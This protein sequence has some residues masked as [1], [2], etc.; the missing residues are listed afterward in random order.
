MRSRPFLAPLP[1]GADVQ[2]RASAG[3]RQEGLQWR[4][5]DESSGGSLPKDVMEWTTSHVK[6]WLY[7]TMPADLT[8]YE[9]RIVVRDS[10]QIKSKLTNFG[11]PHE[12][13][14]KIDTA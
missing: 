8:D 5:R 11:R 3:P 12:E 7:N 10:Y 9:D 6:K 14:L 13:C 1:L 4:V 2:V